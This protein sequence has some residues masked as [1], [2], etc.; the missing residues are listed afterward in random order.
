MVSR[1]GVKFILKVVLSDTFDTVFGGTSKILFL[2]LDMKNYNNLREAQLC[3]ENMTSSLPLR[4]T[5]D[6]SYRVYFNRLLLSV[7]EC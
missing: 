7:P 3:S 1:T 4:K 5:E 6:F 2:V